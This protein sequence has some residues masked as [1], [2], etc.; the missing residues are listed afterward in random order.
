MSLNDME[1]LQR[2]DLLRRRF[3]LTYTQ[4]ETVLEQH[5]WDVVRA[6]VALESEQKSFVEEIKVAGRDL[7]DKLRELIHEGNINRIVVREE[8]GRE[9]L[10]LPIT[11]IAA[12]AILA[13]ILTALAAVVALA[14]NY[15]IE[16]ERQPR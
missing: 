5:G 8:N 12:A 9:V 3:D 6:T 7:V 2:I 10:N 11:G 13:P 1:R 16:V 14:V 4:A 15:T